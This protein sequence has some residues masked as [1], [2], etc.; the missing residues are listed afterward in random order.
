[1]AN[2][3]TIYAQQ[4]GDNIMQLAQQTDSKLFNKVWKK[5]G[6]SGKSFYQDQIGQWVME[7]KAGRNTDT[8]NSDPALARR[9]VNLSDWEDG[10]LLDKEDELKTIS[11]PR[12]AYSMAGGASIG[13]TYDDIIIDAA[14][15]TA[16]TGEEGGTSVTFPTSQIIAASTT[17]LTQAKVLATKL[18]FDEEDV[19]AAGRCFVTSPAGLTDMLAL[20]VVGSSDYNSIRAL[21]NGELNTWLGFE[22]I[23]ST[24]LPLASTTRSCLAFQEYGICL[25]TADS[26]TVR[27]DERRDKSY[28]WQLYY[29]LHAGASRMEEVRVVKVNIIES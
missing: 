7:K 29:S 4:Y 24:R 16:L 9:R 6:V 23:T 15:G 11:N 3:N 8:P 19:P 26:A 25:G 13:R 1:M 2:E 12:S 18:R 20:E 22:W 21:V 17:G 10:H 5:T 27:T 14:F 28:A